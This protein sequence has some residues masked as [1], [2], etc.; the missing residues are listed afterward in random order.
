MCQYIT[1]CT[2]TKHTLCELVCA[3]DIDSIRK[4]CHATRT[5]PNRVL[6]LSPYFL[7]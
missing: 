6:K 1:Y 2:F 4:Y 5:K 3:I 7:K